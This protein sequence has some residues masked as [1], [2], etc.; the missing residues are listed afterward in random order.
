MK[1]SWKE[2]SV[3]GKFDAYND[4]LEQTL[5][6]EYVFRKFDKADIKK[7]LD[8]GC[9]PGKVAYRLADRIDC[10]VIAVDESSK[11]LDIAK[12]KRKHSHVDYHLIEHDNLSFLP[13]HSVDAAMACYVF[14]NTDSDQRIKRIMGE[15][16]RVLKPGASFVILDTNP[17]STG[18]E[19]STFRN[20]IP[21]KEYSYGEERN[22]WLHVPEQEDLILNDFHWPKSMYYKLLSNV[23]FESV[24]LLEPTLNDIDGEQL[25]AIEQKFKFNNWKSE[26]EYPPFIIFEAVKPTLGGV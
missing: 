4:V 12:K 6:F 18:I 14:I 17:D 10:N 13:D 2:D 15:I 8:F 25:K 3:A 9:G 23:G 21:G 26:K 19:F 24:T 5:G 11:M 20:G 16:F 22:E 7:V 1:T